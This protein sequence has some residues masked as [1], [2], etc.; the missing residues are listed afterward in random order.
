MGFMFLNRYIDLADAIDDNGDLTENLD[1]SKTDIP[2]DVHLPRNKHLSVS[3][4]ENFFFKLD[5]FTDF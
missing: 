5:D 3:Y 2:E 1:F 4:L